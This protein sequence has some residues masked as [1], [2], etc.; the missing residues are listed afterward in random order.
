[1]NRNGL[2]RKSH[3][4]T[5]SGSYHGWTALGFLNVGIIVT[6]PHAA[7]TKYFVCVVSLNQP[8]IFMKC[9]LLLS[10][11]E[12]ETKKAKE[13]SHDCT[14]VLQKTLGSLTES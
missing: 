6:C 12:I 11:K 4:S 9:V 2:L 8:H 7:Y 10:N 3:V 13:L 1:M 5:A 14:V